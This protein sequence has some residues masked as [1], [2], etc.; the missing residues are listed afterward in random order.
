MSTCPPKPSQDHPLQSETALSS[1]VEIQL[2]QILGKVAE[3]GFVAFMWVQFCR[4]RRQMETPSSGPS[5]KTSMFEVPLH[6]IDWRMILTARV[7]PLLGEVRSPTTLHLSVAGLNTCSFLCCH[8]LVQRSPLLFVCC[9]QTSPLQL[10]HASLRPGF[11][12]STNINIT[13]TGCFGHL[14]CRYEGSGL[15][16]F[17]D[18][19]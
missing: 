4:I 14:A 17:P 9:V 5:F 15:V 11:K 1:L 6:W 19:P 12:S 16:R 3:L 2:N 7:S 18:P 10:A 8:I 13:G